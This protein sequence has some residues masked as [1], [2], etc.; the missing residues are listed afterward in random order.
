M[1][2][3]LCGVTRANLRFDSDGIMSM[4]PGRGPAR[5]RAL[6]YTQTSRSSGQHTSTPIQGPRARTRRARQ[7]T[8]TPALTSTSTGT[9]LAGTSTVTPAHPSGLLTSAL[10]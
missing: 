7:H 2:R 6:H 9:V 5:G 4:P 10:A 8:S 1:L 3:R